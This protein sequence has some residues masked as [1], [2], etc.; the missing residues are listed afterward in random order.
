M[1]TALIGVKLVE[2]FFF[3]GNFDMMQF[4]YMGLILIGIVGLKRNP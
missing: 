2:L 4:V 3:K 1:G